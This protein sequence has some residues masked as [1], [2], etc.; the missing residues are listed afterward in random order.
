MVEFSLPVRGES[1]SK[2]SDRASRGR[3]PKIS[4]HTA[5]KKQFKHGTNQTINKILKKF[6]RS[7]IHQNLKTCRENRQ[8]TISKKKK[9]NTLQQSITLTLSFAAVVTLLDIL[10]SLLL[11]ILKPD[12]LRLPDP[13]HQHQQGPREPLRACRPSRLLHTRPITHSHGLLVKTIAPPVAPNIEATKNLGHTEK[14]S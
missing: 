2:A 3:V 11:T 5:I 10:L 1:A 14:K 4:L 12:L 13:R 7:I 9:A 8:H 6:P